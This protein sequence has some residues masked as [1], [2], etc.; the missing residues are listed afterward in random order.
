MNFLHWLFENGHR[1]TV[2]AAVYRNWAVFIAALGILTAVVSI[3][4]CLVL[5]GDAGPLTIRVGGSI[6][7]AELGFAFLMVKM[8]VTGLVL[9]VPRLSEA[10]GEKINKTV[11]GLTLWVSIYILLCMMVPIR[12]SVPTFALM[13]ACVF[14][15]MM[16]VH[17]GW[18]QG[19]IF[20]YLVSAAVIGIGGWSFVRLSAPEIT[21]EAGAF[22]GKMVD[23]AKEA[24]SYRTLLSGD[25]LAD[26][27]S[28]HKTM[29]SRIDSARDEMRK[30]KS[31]LVACVVD[32]CPD[33]ARLEQEYRQATDTLRFLE[34]DVPLEEE[35]KPEPP[36]PK[37]KNIAAP[38]ESDILAEADALLKNLGF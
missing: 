29:R 2:R 14:M 31:A 25:A 19:R 34:G 21:Q 3:A 38:A 28:D 24:V 36:Q 30:R 27:E 15:G 13:T 4:M 37:K 16:I 10:D 18:F 6:A 8:A 20:K 26:A 9:L 12:E 23:A 22:S 11:V 33:R 35:E 1:W 5:G 17:R 7:I 32:E